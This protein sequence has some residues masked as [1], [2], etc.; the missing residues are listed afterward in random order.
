M[1]AHRRS[2]VDRAYP[3]PSS[4]LA[5][6][7]SSLGSSLVLPSA[8]VVVAVHPQTGLQH[9]ELVIVA[10]TAAMYVLGFGDELQCGFRINIA[11]DQHRFDF[12]QGSP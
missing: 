2:I 4:T 8:G 11:F 7:C 5:R 3:D 6:H 12:I 9:L 10:F 1:L